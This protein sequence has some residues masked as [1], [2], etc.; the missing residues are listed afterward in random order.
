MRRVGGVVAVLRGV[1]E[2]P[3]LAN[4]RWVR[5]RAADDFSHQFRA[6]RCDARHPEPPLGVQ[7]EFA[8]TR[9]VAEVVDAQRGQDG[10]D[11]VVVREVG[12][13]GRAE[14]EGLGRAVEGA[15][16][17]TVAGGEGLVEQAREEFLRVAE[18]LGAAGGVSGAVVVLEVLVLWS[19]VTGSFDIQGGLTVVSDSLRMLKTG[20]FGFGEEAAEV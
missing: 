2:R 17:A 8:Q 10:D 15:V 13:E 6:E 11:D 5:I 20:P 12:V 14:G 18:A 9:R 16:G 1:V 3:A 7:R 4:G 19:C